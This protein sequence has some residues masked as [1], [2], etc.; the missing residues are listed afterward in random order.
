ML[1]MDP[2]SIVDGGVEDV[3]G[4]DCATEDQLVTVWN[5]LPFLIRGWFVNIWVLFGNGCC[6]FRVMHYC[7]GFGPSIA[8]TSGKQETL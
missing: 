8:Y 3:Y 4:K 7:R 1:D 6:I 2:K 5:P